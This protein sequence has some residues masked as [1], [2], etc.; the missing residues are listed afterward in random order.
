MMNGFWEES[1]RWESPALLLPHSALVRVLLAAA[2][3]VLLPPSKAVRG[4]E[5]VSSSLGFPA[6]SHWKTGHGG[7]PGGVVAR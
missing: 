2:E 7:G 5:Y 4:L 6:G 1:H 3:W